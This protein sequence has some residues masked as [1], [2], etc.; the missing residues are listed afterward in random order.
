MRPAVARIVPPVSVVL[1]L[2]SIGAGLWAMIAPRS[3][4]ANAATYPPYSRHFI[5]DIGAF[6]I[7]LGGGLLAGVL[8]RDALLAAL[9]GNALGAAAHFVGH[10]VDRSQ[11]GHASDPLTFGVLAL[12]LVALTIARWSTRDGGSDGPGP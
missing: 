3:F 5:H 12:V 1:A 4:Y 2:I 7:G 6:Q 9:A 8:L 11:G 10:V